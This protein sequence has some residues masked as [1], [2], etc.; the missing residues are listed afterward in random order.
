VAASLIGQK[1][2]KYEIT[3]LIGHGGMATVY[4]GYQRDIDR[5]VAI[6]VMP[7]HPGQDA[8][9]V[10]RF[11]LEARTVAR[12]QHPHIL[13]IYDYGDENGILYLVMALAEGGTLSD[14][15]RRGPM[16][17]EEVERL[18]RQI[19]SA[20]DY[21][22]R[23]GVVHRDIK[24]E[25]ILINREGYTL[26]ADFGIV[27][28]TE[29]SSGM[30]ITGGLVG[31]PTYMSPEQGQG[32][33]VDHRSD[34]YSLGV[35]MY[36]MLTGTQPYTADTP[37]Q[38]VFKHITEP[39]PDILSVRPDLPAPIGDVMRKA[40]AKEPAAR[41]SSGK[42]LIDD[43]NAALHGGTIILT[44]TPPAGAL[45]TVEARPPLA[46]E[47]LQATMVT[48]PPTVNPLILLGGFA[49]IAVLLVVVVLVVLNSREGIPPAT[50]TAVALRAVPTFGRVSFSTTAVS[51]DTARIE[52]EQLPPP[53]SGKRYIA[54][55][56]AGEDNWIKMGNL[57]LDPLGGAALIYTDD[58]ARNLSTLYNRVLITLEENDADTPG[59]VV[60][61]N[62]AVP[63]AVTDALREIIVA[64]SEGFDNASLLESAL[65]EAR[66]AR[67]HAGLAANSTNV[68]GLHTHAEHTIN[69]L[70]GTT[71]DFTGDGRGDNPGRG[72]GVVHFVDLINAHLDAAA[73]AANE[74]RQV[75]SQIELIRVCTANAS[76]WIEQVIALEI[77]LTQADD[78]DAVASQRSQSTE[79]A[80]ALI[81]GVD[82][83]QNRQVDPFE[84]ECGLE[85]IM[86]YSV[87][88]GNMDIVAVDGA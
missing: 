67:Q 45:P 58:E 40:L 63:Q 46:T 84:G 23:Q 16:A 85:Q 24:P 9:Y 62:G 55:L 4:K 26:L 38:L 37:M 44:P 30:T 86:T 14:L 31:T 47:Q 74:M 11:R 22:H 1:L 34:L 52:V 18:M 7:P 39:T 60:A 27:K 66:I 35:V 87:A 19:T 21:A 13:P 69:I 12:L 2:G 70:R 71:E 76:G 43:F 78:V 41:Y 17:L 51:G 81:E 72:V 49:I 80:A 59:S 15:I 77:A 82:L 33:S 5:H 54:W 57:L 20:L 42:A 73:T 65:I 88:V 53:P 56:G 29:G 64:S 61:Y 36:E 75:Q 32:L 28:I 8:N 50:P 68:G 3:E 83:N 79:L 25:N 10:E 48:P 6:K